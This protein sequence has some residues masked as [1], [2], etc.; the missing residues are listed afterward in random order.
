M[1]TALFDYHLPPEL[2]AQEPLPD[3]ESSRLLVLHR[4]TRTWEDRGVRDLPEFLRSGDVMVFNDTR[5]VPARLRAT[6]DLSGGKIEFLL[7]PPPPEGWGDTPGRA[8]AVRRVLTRAGGTLKTGESFTLSGGCKAVL[9]ERHGVAGDLVAFQCAPEEFERHMWEHGEIP[10]PPYIHRPAG[11]SRDADRRRYQTVYAHDPGAV[12]APTAGLHFS[13]TLLGALR[14]RGVQTCFL[15]LH[16]G[17]GTFRPVKS[18]RVEEHFIDPE[19]YAISLETAAAVRRAKEEGRRVIAVGTTSLRA[20]EGSLATPSPYPLPQGEGGN[21]SARRGTTDLFV[22][23]PREF[24]IVDALVTNFHLPRSSLLMLVAAFA[25]PGGME[26]IEFVRRAYAH[27]VES[28]YR[29][30]SYGDACLFV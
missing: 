9:L 11:P 5:V 13:D 30:F 3:R 2:I 10:L 18:E 6:R 29:F 27:A 19:P 8:P 17:P 21:N 22:Y 1:D 12:A 4:A 20:L 15:T 14:A 16:V 26:G 25:A 7:C 24:R 28:R 23:P